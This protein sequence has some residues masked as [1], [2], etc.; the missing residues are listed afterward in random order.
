MLFRCI[1]VQNFR[2]LTSP[3][4]IE[5]LGPGVTIIAGDN[6]EGKSTLLLA[7][8]TGLF[9][10]HNLGGRAAEAMQPF[11]STVRPQIGLDFEI[12]GESYSITK[13]FVRRPSALLITPDGKLEGPAAEDRLAE[14]LRF[15][16]TLRG[17]SRPE[18]RG[19]LGLFWLEQGRVL[20]GVEC[21]E[22]GRSTLRSS[23][24]QEVG[25]VLGGARGCRLIEGA[26]AKRDAWLTATGRPRGD[27]AAAIEEAESA[28]RRVTELEFERQT[29]DQEIENLARDRR[30]LARIDG[31]KVLEKAREA[32]LAADEQAETIEQIRQQDQAAG[33]A[34]SLA[35]AQ[36]ENI[37]DRWARRLALIQMSTDREKISHH[38]ATKLLAL[39]AETQSLLSRRNEAEAALFKAVEDRNVA[40]RRVAISQSWARAKMLDA[41]IAELDRRLRELDRLV[42]QR[43]AAQRRL[44]G[45][46]IDQQ[47][48]DELQNLES[49]MREARA[50]LGAIATRVRFL[51]L[52]GQRVTK[53]DEEIQVGESIEIT[54]ATRFTLAG[55]GR[56]DIEPGAS[57]LA[58]RRAR[59]EA[60][61]IALSNALAAVAVTNLAQA[62]SG[63]EER[64]EAETVV[65]EANRL[66]TVY[67]PEGAGAL[68]T[69]LQE[70]SAERLHLNEANGF[71]LTRDIDD[72]GTEIQALVSTR[73]GE[74]TAR[75]ALGTAEKEH[76]EH[77]TQLAVAGQALAT[78]QEALTAAKENLETAR[79][80]VSD[81]DLRARLDGAHGSVTEKQHRKT[82]A[83]K[84]LLAANPEEVRLR[85]DRAEAAL[86]TVEI[87]QRRLRDNVIGLESRL[88]AL[89]KGGIG[90]LLEEARE[91]AARA[92]FRRDRLQADARAWDLLVRTLRSAERDAKEKFLEPILKTIDPFLR[93]VFPCARL[94]LNEETLEISR[95]TRDGRE[96]PYA[97]LSVGTREQLSILVRL[98]FAVY[99]RE[100]GYPAAVIL[101]DALV[102]ADDDR[103]ERMQ[104]ALRKAAETVQILILTCRPRDW[105]QFGAPIRH[106]AD[107]TTAALE[108]A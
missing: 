18:D 79:A 46:K 13:G 94:A 48:F 101:D 102:Y 20:E 63:L 43:T 66:I 14:L 10:R 105:R 91:Q 75:R 54:E 108:L 44:S 84:R 52:D 74:E 80:E 99:L 69:A 100:K 29:Y 68:G 58:A 76:Q 89:G 50:A 1:S 3:A 19:I 78:A 86:R 24:E 8:R 7:I 49:V 9:E 4:V 62:R 15:R 30:E 95:I 65:K 59:F 88:A 97:V 70:K 98:A 92:V 11:G 37:R 27:L 107:V 73:A 6:E 93:L 45:I 104:L 39:E 5:G 96:E 32:L 61:K 16:L 106:L 87:E 77:I 67:A 28:A 2:K 71:P 56:I 23:L 85:R 31:D 90:E 53:N 26:S 38:A 21:G 60:A 25:D 57:E 41:E 36:A 17:E 47:S 64:I 81:A 82:E 40:E 33:Q 12:D 55:F 35:E 83:E 72:P 34:V 103:F 42:A 51:P 22:L